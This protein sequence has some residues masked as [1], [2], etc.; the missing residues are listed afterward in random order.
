MLKLIPWAHLEEKDMKEVKVKT[1]QIIEN[2]IK[3]NW[4][5]WTLGTV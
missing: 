5:K 4:Y 3:L 2:I 1:R